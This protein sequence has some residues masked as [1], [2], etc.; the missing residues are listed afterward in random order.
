VRKQLAIST[1]Q[2]AKAN[3]LTTEGPEWHR[4]T[5]EGFFAAMFPVISLF[6]PVHSLFQ[7]S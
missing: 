5:G 4:G 3:T 7:M 1:W 6:L 2:L